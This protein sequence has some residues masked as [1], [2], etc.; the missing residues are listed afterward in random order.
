MCHYLKSLGLYSIVLL[1]TQWA[2]AEDVRQ[3][4]MVIDN[5]FLADLNPSKLM[6]MPLSD[7]KL[8]G[9][10]TELFL[11]SEG[12]QPTWQLVARED[13]QRRGN[14]ATPLLLSLFQ[15][16]PKQRFRDELMRNIGDHPSIDPTPF[17]V[18]ATKLIEEDGLRLAPRTC[19]AIA[20]FFTKAG[21]KNDLDTLKLLLNSENQEVRLFLPGKI[22][23]MERRLVSSPG[24]KKA[25]IKRQGIMT[26]ASTSATSITEPSDQDQASTTKTTSSSI[27]FPAFTVKWVSVCLVALTLAFCLWLWLRKM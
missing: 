8:K 5:A 13:L 10:Y 17:L 22:A 7:P 27:L 20:D 1:Y 15:E 14:E 3:S 26:N 23:R 2:N 25:D 21:S 6:G 16:N 19:Y 9:V 12:I 4:S 11:Q 24:G 18:A